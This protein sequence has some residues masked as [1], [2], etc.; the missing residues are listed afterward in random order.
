MKGSGQWFDP[1]IVS[2]QIC[3]FGY[4][5]FTNPLKVGNWRYIVELIQSFKKPIVDFNTLMMKRIT[6]CLLAMIG[7]LCLSTFQAEAQNAPYTVIEGAETAQAQLLGK[8]RPLRE[9]AEES[10]LRYNHRDKA[11]ET[12]SG[13]MPNFGN[14]NKMPTPFEHEAAPKHGDPLLQGDP[15]KLLT[16]V[17][18]DFVIEGMDANDAQIFPPDTNGDIGENHYVQMINSQGGALITVFDKITG[19]VVQDPMNLTLLWEEFNAVGFGDGIVLYDQAADRWMLAEFGPLGTTVIYIAISETSDPM[20]SYFA[21]EFQTPNFPDYPKFG[22]WDDAIVFTTNEGGEDFMPIYLVNRNAMLNGEPFANAQLLTGMPKF[23][24]AAFAFQ[25]AS[26]VDWDGSAPPP[27]DS[28]QV[29]LRLYDD[30]WEGGQD[31]LELWEINVDW[32]NPGNTSLAGPLVLPTAPFDSDVCNGG[33]FNC[34]DHFGGNGLLSAIMQV[35]MH[36]PQYRNFGTHESIVLNFTVDVD[37]SNTAGIRWIE[38]RK[39]GAGDWAIFQEGTFSPDEN[40]RFMGSIAQD[41]AGNILM[42]YSITALDKELSLRYTGRLAGDPL[43]E[44]TIE[45]FEFAP[46]ESEYFSFRWGDYASMNVDPN[47]DRTFWF[48]GEYMRAN[49]WGTK[50]VTAQIRRDSLDIGP[51]GL[52]APQNSAFLT[53]TEEISGRGPQFR[54]AAFSGFHDLL[55]GR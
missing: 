28:P 48:T 35:I 8:S 5:G 27:E 54:L 21:Y 41:G 15:D 4:K 14:S 38:L 39:S 33:I 31:A 6:L 22:I 46:G 16:I 51:Q 52:T 18:P 13:E 43:G 2:P 29:V 55:S 47:D 9:I 19:E 49:D 25:T 10:S 3:H 26:V 32:D 20:G 1:F 24:P 36:R 50:I 7:L 17:E 30:A 44:M 23:N 45:E 42:G 53:D 37:G 40:N 11:K 12:F 34:I